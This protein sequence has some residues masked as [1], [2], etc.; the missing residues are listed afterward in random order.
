MRLVVSMIRGDPDI[1]LDARP[2]HGDPQRR[3]P[4]FVELHA[5]SKETGLVPVWG[6]RVKGFGQNGGSFLMP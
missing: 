1:D 4:L 3:D 6:S 2:Y 5:V